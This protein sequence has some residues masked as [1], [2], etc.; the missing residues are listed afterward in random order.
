MSD[1]PLIKRGSELVLKIES[2]AYGG[3]GLAR[4]S[5]F[6]IF[7]KQA[8]PGQKVLVR[9]YKK[10]RGYA[11]A[12]VIKLLNESP[13]A[14]DVCCNH[15]W[16]CSKL[17]S[18]SYSEQLK[19]KSAQV[20]DAF[21][22]IGG[23][24]DF[25]LEKVRPAKNI[26]HYRNKMEFTFSPNRWVLASEPEGVDRSFA[27]GLHIPGR[28]DKI[29]DIKN[30]HIQP[31]IGNKILSLTRE[32]CLKHSE[33]RPY[34]PRSH[35]GFLRFLMIRYGINTGNLMVNLVTSYHDINKISPLTD[36]LLENFPEITSLV[37]NVNTRKADVAFGEYETLLF[38]ESFIREKIDDLTFEISANSFFQTNT[39]QGEI[40]YE[41]VKNLIG[42]KG[43]E[44]VYDLYCGTGTIALF[45]SK[46]AKTV[47]GFEVI[48]SALDD[49]E[50]NADIND[51]SNVHFIKA[52]LDTYFK[53]GQLPKR[54][55]KPDVIVVDPPRAGLHKDMSSY[56]PKLKAKKIVY[57]SCNPTTQARDAKI[58][59]ENG[60]EITR[61]VMVDMFP[62]TPHIEMVL[63][64]SK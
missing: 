48:R 32:V 22:R 39:F 21:N 20:E 61:S 49:A 62:H 10:R 29:L 44:I 5:N 63:L 34:D 53:S 26:Y 56:L 3:M 9:V 36:A 58:L 42:L 24:H 54:I 51:I 25:K 57:I 55:P 4:E 40:L 33:L 2:L 38:G 45:L 14:I 18:L 59:F 60:Y 52:N 43:D 64:F 23:F 16:I 13:N 41:E 1:A 47:Y 15:Y 6:V 37:N 12:R 11:E 30:C 28:F 8:I 7:V 27:L 31:E 35:I 50:K 46:N 19:E 17:Q